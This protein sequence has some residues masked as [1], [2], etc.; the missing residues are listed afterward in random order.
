VSWT[1]GKNR[2][3]VSASQIVVILP[4]GTVPTQNPGLQNTVSPQGGQQVTPRGTQP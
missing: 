2:R 1:D 4:Q 3:S